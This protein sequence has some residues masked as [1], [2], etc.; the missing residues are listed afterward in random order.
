MASLFLSR[1]SQ[2]DRG[3]LVQQLHALQKGHCFICEQGIDLVAQKAVLD[4]DHVVP[5]KVGGKDEPSN[6][7]LAHQSCNR[8]KQASNLEVARVLSRFSRLKDQ[9]AVENRSPSLGDVLKQVNGGQHELGFSLQG[10]EVV[11]SLAELGDPALRRVPVYRDPLSG[12][13]YFFVELPIEYL[14]HDGHINP[15]T[16]GANIGKLVEEFF[17]KRPQLHVPLAWINSGQ[18]RSPVAVFDGQHKAAAQIMLGVRR[19]PVRVFIDPDPDVLI[20]TNTNAGTTLKQVAFDK[21]VQRSLG[22]S[23]YQERLQRF[24]KATGRAEQDLGFSEKALIDHFRGQSREIKRYILDAVRNGITA[25]P[26]NKLMAFVDM[27][28]RGTDHPLSYSTVEKTFYSFFIHQEVLETPL[29][30]LLE[31]GE[32]PRELERSQIVK[33]MNLIAEELYLGKFDESIGTDKLENRLR[34]GDQLPLDHI[35]AYRIS[36]E[37]IVYNWLQYVRQIAQ[38][39]FIMQGKPDPHSRLFQIPFPEQIW[40]NQR[41]FLR[42]L[43]ALPVWVNLELSDSVF[44]GKQNNSTW[45]TIFETGKTPQ[46]MQVLAKPINLIEMIQ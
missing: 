38:Q 29:N 42:S 13:R 5:L 27:S 23:L 16:I 25:D 15:R 20:T 24:Q 19:L 6:F 22:H 44:G 8:S 31:E 9:L 46:G 4:I 28:G 10:D 32:N 39:F 43:I 45:K 11:Y 30:H 3:G 33:L 26:D 1:L 21:S 18:N 41:R 37:E 40:D 14:A 12:F 17:N 34:K 36:K 2:A 35:R 7:A